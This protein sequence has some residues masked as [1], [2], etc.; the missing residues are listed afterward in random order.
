[1]NLLVV[2]DGDC[3]FCERSVHFVHSRL[4]P[5]SRCTIEFVPWQSLNLAAHGLTEYHV[6]RA[7]WLLR[8][9]GTRDSGAAVFGL[10]ARRSRGLWPI[11]GYAMRVPPLSWAAAGAYRVV[12]ANRHR[13]P[14]SATCAVRSASR[15]P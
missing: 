12:A 6:A 2:Y 10:L 11:L 3:G 1:M 7:V 15:G 13:L 8:P 14:G 5:S 4:R 9:D